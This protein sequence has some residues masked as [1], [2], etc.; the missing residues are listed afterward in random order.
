VAYVHEVVAGEH[1][2]DAV[3][4]RV[5][6]ERLEKLGASVEEVF[7]FEKGGS[8]PEKLLGGFIA[9]VL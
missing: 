4:F 6:L 1:E 8:L 9:V 5:V 3:I 7:R 2:V